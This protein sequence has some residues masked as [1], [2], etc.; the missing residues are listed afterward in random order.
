MEVV[1][2]ETPFF[3]IGQITLGGIILVILGSAMNIPWIWDTIKKRREEKKEK[4]QTTAPN[5]SQG[6]KQ[7]KKKQH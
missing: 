7:R 6:R 5:K 4:H 3:S 2:P 1:D